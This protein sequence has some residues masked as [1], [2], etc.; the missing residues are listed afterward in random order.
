MPGGVSPSVPLLSTLATPSPPPRS[1]R[2][3]TDARQRTQRCATS[4]E[5]R[6]PDAHQ[7]CHPPPSWAS[8][9]TPPMRRTKPPDQ[10]TSW[11]TTPSRGKPTLQSCTQRADKQADEELG[12]LQGIP[13]ASNLVSRSKP[14]GCQASIHV[15][16]PA[17]R[18]GKAN[19]QNSCASAGVDETS[20][21]KPGSQRRSDRREGESISHAGPALGLRARRLRGV[22]GSP[23][24]PWRG[25][26]G[27]LAWGF[28]HQKLRGVYCLLIKR[29]I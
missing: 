21:R 2:T 29:R 26:G 11:A 17:L 13:Q 8:K 16:W 28:C 6:R 3:V 4:S 18:C 27:P 23:A 19:T 22:R 9:R 15:T 7:P 1:S 10:S 14:S 25:A 24:L 20:G 5:G 12:D